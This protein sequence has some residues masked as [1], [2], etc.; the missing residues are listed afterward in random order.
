MA[1]ATCGCVPNSSSSGFTIMPPPIPSRPARAT[2]AYPKRSKEPWGHSPEQKPGAMLHQTHRNPCV[3]PVDD[4]QSTCKEGCTFI[5]VGCSETCSRRQ[6]G[7]CDEAGEEGDDGGSDEARQRPGGRLLVHARQHRLLQPILLA[8][9]LASTHLPWHRAYASNTF[10]QNGQHT[11]QHMEL[12]PGGRSLSNLID[13][14][15]M[16]K[17]RSVMGA[18]KLTCAMCSLKAP[19]H[20]LTCSVP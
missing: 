20:M 9:L 6:G 4:C 11:D 5:T 12:C 3:G 10:A 8:A 14:G 13:G 2:R 15:S 19:H 7:T 17:G 1:A 16:Q 18:I